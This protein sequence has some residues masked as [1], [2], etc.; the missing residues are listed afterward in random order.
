MNIMKKENKTNVCVLK[1]VLFVV[2]L[3]ANCV[4]GMAQVKVVDGVSG[5]AVSYASIFDDATGKVLGITNSEGLLPAAADSCQTISV[6]HINYDPVTVERSSV[7]DGVIKLA[8]RKAYEVKEVAVDR[9]NHDYIRLK[10]YTRDYTVVNGMVA[11]VTESVGYGYFDSKSRR[12]KEDQCLMMRHLRNEDAFNGQKIIVQAFAECD[13]PSYDGRIARSVA[14]FDKYNDGKKHREYDKNG[15]KTVTYFVRNNEAEK[16]IELVSDSALV[17]K[18]INFWLFGV[19]LSDGYGLATFNSAYGKP[20]LSTMQN[21]FMVYR[22]THNKSQ[23]SVTIFRERYVL[24]V[25]FAN[26]EDFKAI[27]KELKEKEK[28]GTAE[29]FVRPAG[30]PPFSKY[31]DE[32]MKSMK[33]LHE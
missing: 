3:F 7:T 27:K 15:V 29:K 25:D 30:L 5:Q 12:H 4:L 23:V 16:R 19:S 10:M 9:D 14:F 11:E 8:S 32:A 22:M 20:S 26:K 33:V 2:L 1:R 24:G 21:H 18:P 31:V 13:K 28:A 17:D 6:Q